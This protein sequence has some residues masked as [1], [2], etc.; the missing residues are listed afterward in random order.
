MYIYIHICLS[1]TRRR[2]SERLMM[3]FVPAGTAT[4][5]TAVLHAARRNTE[6]TGTSKRKTS[7]ATPVATALLDSTCTNVAN[8]NVKITEQ[9]AQPTRAV[10]AAELPVVLERQQDIP[11]MRGR[12]HVPGTELGVTRRKHER[13]G[14]ATNDRYQPQTAATNIPQTALEPVNFHHH[15]MIHTSTRT[16]SIC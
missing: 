2:T 12:S 15:L 13:L 7:C 9:R 10:V 1:D 8:S 5:P 6:R 11:L 3:Q 4:P 16:P 14:I